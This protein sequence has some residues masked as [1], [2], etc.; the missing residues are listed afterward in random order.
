MDDPTFIRHYNARHP[1]LSRTLGDLPDDL[2]PDEVDRY[3][4]LHIAAHRDYPGTGHHHNKRDWRK[5]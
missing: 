1:E 3:R 4:A 5:P 2:S